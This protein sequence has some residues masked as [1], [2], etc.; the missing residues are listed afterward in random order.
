MLIRSERHA[1]RVLGEFVQHYNCDR[2]HR[3]INLEAPVPYVTD[4]EFHGARGMR[5]VDRLGLTSPRSAPCLVRMG[6][7][8]I[9]LPRRPLDAPSLA[10]SACSTAKSGLASSIC[11]YFGQQCGGVGTQIAW[12]HP[13][14][15]LH[16]SYPPRRLGGGAL[17]R[18]VRGT[19]RASEQL[20]VPS[21][22]PRC[23]AGERQV[24]QWPLSQS[25]TGPCAAA[26]E[27][28]PS[29]RLPQAVPLQLQHP[30]GSRLTLFTSGR[31]SSA[32]LH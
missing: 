15:N 6:R 20:V 5:R 29:E 31:Q 17:G 22:R 14:S 2:P 13:T 18:S 1:E 27:I 16:P 21:G 12:L 3:G 10:L 8:R 24:Q 25:A 23:L 26:V 7:C 30:A 9:S 11:P 4:D 32:R 28:G 19:R